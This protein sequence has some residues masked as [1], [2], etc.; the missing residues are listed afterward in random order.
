[1]VEAL[2]KELK[3]KYPDLTP[4]QIELYYIQIATQLIL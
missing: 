3:K 4:E 2:E 1:M